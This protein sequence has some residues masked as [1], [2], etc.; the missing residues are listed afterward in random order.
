MKKKNLQRVLLSR[1]DGSPPMAWRHFLWTYVGGATMRNESSVWPE[2]GMPGRAAREQC[3]WGRH[4]LWD[5]NNNNNDNNSNNINNNN[6]IELQTGNVVHKTADLSGD[7]L[8][9]VVPRKAVMWHYHTAFLVESGWWRGRVC[10]VIVWCRHCDVTRKASSAGF[11]T[12]H[13]ESVI[14]VWKET[15]YL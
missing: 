12:T 6:S 1:S 14:S 9:R 7:Q 10:D 5:C 15:L 11:V 8:M 13:P 3:L 4:R 2:V